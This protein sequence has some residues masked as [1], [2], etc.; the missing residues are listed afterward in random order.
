MT[1]KPKILIVDDEKNFR[2]IFSTKLSAS[3]FDTI[4]AGDGKEAIMIAKKEKPDLVLMDIHMA[5]E[6]GTDIALTIK[7]TPETKNMKVA[8]LTNLKE[9]WPAVTG[10][11]KNIA[12]ELGMDDYLE[13][14]DDLDSLVQ[15]VQAILSGQPTDA[16]SKEAVPAE[17][18]KE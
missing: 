17:T 12:K 16:Q 8:F 13:K 1:G 3:G 5:G 18:K 10:D 4:T 15:K 11:H 2:E 6:S 9:P 7:Q 14:T